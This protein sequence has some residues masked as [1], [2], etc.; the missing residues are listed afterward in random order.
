MSSKPSFRVASGLTKMPLVEIDGASDGRQPH[1]KRKVTSVI[2]KNDDLRVI[3][4]NTLP[5][6]T[7]AQGT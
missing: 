2:L 6:E 5:P 1:S 4:N 3:V 7:E